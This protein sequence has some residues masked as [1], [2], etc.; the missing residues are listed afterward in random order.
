MLVS[1]GILKKQTVLLFLGL[2]V[3]IFNACDDST[4]FQGAPEIT[5][6][7]PG[8]GTPGTIVTIFGSGFSE[9]PSENRVAFNGVHADVTSA[10]TDTIVT[11]VPEEASS[12]VVEVVVGSQNAVGPNFIVNQSTGTLEISASTTGEELD[13]DGYTATL[14]STA[15][16]RTLAPQGTSIFEN[17]T[18][19][20]Q[21][22]EISGIAAN[23]NLEG[24]NPR[25]V[26]IIQGETVSISLK[27]TCNLIEQIAFSSTRTGNADVWKIESTGANSV[28][29]SNNPASDSRPFWSPNGKKIAFLSYRNGDANIEIWVMNP[30]GSE[31]KQLTNNPSGEVFAPDWSPDGSKIVFSNNRSGNFE[32]RL[33]DADGTNPK[34]LT[35]DPGVD[36]GPRWSPDGSEIIFV[37]NRTGN[38][39]IWIMDA[40][41]LN[42]TQL[43]NNPEFDE[44]PIWSPD[45]SQIAFESKRSGNRDIWLMEADGTNLKNLTNNPGF[46]HFAC[47]SPDGTKIAFRSNR[48]G[49]F[50]IWVIDANGTNLTMLTNDPATDVNPRWSPGGSRISFLSNRSG[51]FQIFIMDADGTNLKQLTRSPEGNLNHRWQPR[52]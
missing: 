24:D 6:I 30:D 4:D 42:K 10:S 21:M 38:N 7:S 26:T 11:T 46:D 33:I 39:D 45:G 16:E 47:W 20:E 29:L 49:N 28:N 31:Q 41:G 44:K 23:C 48:T 35:A 22:L 3:F 13:P 18:A 51:N 25:R 36:S 17:V 12:G 43:T 19:G 14:Q 52:Q 32:I 34:K 8:M 27:V 5:S 9:M 1:M 40:N 50:E 37:S 15:E 2:A